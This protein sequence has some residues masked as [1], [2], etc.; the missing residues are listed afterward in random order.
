MILKADIPD[1]YIELLP[2]GRKQAM[3]KLRKVILE[4]LPKG[5]EETII[6]G[7]IG[8]VVPK[9]IFPDGYHCNPKL[10]LPFVNIATQKNFMA[11]YH[12]GLY[13]D[14]ELMDWFTQKYA[15]Q[16]KTKPDMGKSCLRFKKAEHIPYELIGELI[17]KMSVEKWISIYKSM[18]KK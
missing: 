10:P 13:A 12:M 3:S 7:S 1:Q 18:L 5:F 14:K 17:S 16:I 4:N 6:Y 11:L 15:E 2:E 8:Y 9:S